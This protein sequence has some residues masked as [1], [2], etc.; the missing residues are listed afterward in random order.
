M[1]IRRLVVGQQFVFA[2]RVLEIVRVY[3]E[4]DASPVVVM[5]HNPPPPALPGQYALWS[6]DRVERAIA[7]FLAGGPLPTH[8]TST[9]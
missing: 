1:I 4:K 5:E 9:G 3:G 2:G 6:V 8:E 7:E